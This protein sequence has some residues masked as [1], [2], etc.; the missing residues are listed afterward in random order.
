[1]GDADYFNTPLTVLEKNKRFLSH[2]RNMAI[3]VLPYLYMD[4]LLGGGLH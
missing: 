2:E 1:M 4:L 3:S